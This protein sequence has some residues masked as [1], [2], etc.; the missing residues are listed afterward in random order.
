MT[1]RCRDLSGNIIFDADTMPTAGVCLGAFDIPA[2]VAF[3]QTFPGYTGST[4]RVLD[5]RGSTAW[6]Y[7]VD[8]DLGYPRVTSPAVAGDRYSVTVWAMT[9]PSLTPPTG[10][11]V[12]RADQTSIVLAPGGTGLYYLGSASVVSTTANSGL[13]TGSGSMGYHTLE[14]TSSVPIIPVLEVLQG[15][16]TQLIEV[17]RPTSTLYRFKA[18]RC[19]QSS[20]DATGFAT[21]S[22]PRI[23]CYGRRTAPIG[24]PFC[25]VKRENGELAWDLMAG[26]NVLLGAL[27]TPTIAASA[28]SQ[29][30]VVG[31]ASET[32]GVIGPNGGF[33]RTGTVSGAT[34]RMREL[35]RMFNRSS[36]GNLVSNEIATFSYLADSNETSSL[37]YVAPLFVTRH[38]GI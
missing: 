31:N 33:R 12:T 8:N 9:K 17:T 37:Q 25:Y 24:P 2:G 14:F 15:Y 27:A 21:L 34:W 29:S 3:S 16:H 18:R 13:L 20:S 32:C 22:A 26:Q 36:D 35:E 5:A 1:F 4:I 11:T 6:G 23:L 10:I 38:T 19:D 30:F 28:G 7:T